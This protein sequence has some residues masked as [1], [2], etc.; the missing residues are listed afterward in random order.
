MLYI[1]EAYDTQGQDRAGRAHPVI[2]T[3]YNDKDGLAVV[4]YNTGEIELVLGRR[5][6]ERLINGIGPCLGDRQ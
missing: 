5:K 6:F 4:A 3:P 2:L 1:P